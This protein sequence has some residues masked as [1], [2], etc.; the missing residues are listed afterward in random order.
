[1]LQFWRIR[2]LEEFVIRINAAE[3]HQRVGEILSK[4]RFG[5]ERFVIERRG[6]PVAAVVTMQDLARL[7]N[8]TGTRA[9]RR[10]KAE[11]LAMLE[12]ARAVRQMI[13][14]QRRGKPLSN[15]ADLIRQLREERGNAIANLH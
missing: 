8:L 2:Q 12:R 5:D 10:T 4:I 15:S 7:E 11:R 3:L 13:L 9:V 1:M 6:V 14:K